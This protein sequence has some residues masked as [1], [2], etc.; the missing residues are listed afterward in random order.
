VAFHAG[1]DQA[2]EQRE[3]LTAE[4]KPFG[5]DGA[6]LLMAAC[7]AAVALA[8]W[9]TGRFAPQAAGSGI[10]HVKGVEQGQLSLW[11]LS[12]VWVKFVGGIVGI[13]GGLVLGREGP[14]VQMGASLADHLG[15]RFGLGVA[16]RRTLL[17]VGAGAGL[18]G[19]FNAPL[20][21]TLFA[22]EELGAPFRPVVYLGTLLAA[23]VTD[24]CVRFWLGQPAELSIPAALAPPLSTLGP[25]LLVGAA[26]G[27]FGAFFNG[28]LLRAL[29]LADRFRRRAPGWT[30]GAVLGAALG[31]VAWFVPD[32]PGGG[33]L[34]ARHVLDGSPPLREV[35]WLLP[36][37]FALTVASF[38]VGAPGGIFAP[39]LVLGA[40][41]GSA[42]HAGW[43]ALLPAWPASMPLLAAAGMAGLFAAVVRSPLTGAVLM[44]EM[45]GS[46]T[47]MLSV[48]AASLAAHAAAA[49]LGSEPIYD[50]LLARELRRGRG[51]S[52]APA[53]VQKR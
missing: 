19:A 17:V 53:E 28:T 6:L 34:F 50:S 20:A 43:L 31:A 33:V 2:L 45:T 15:L 49:A 12:V 42:L 9:L 22:V 29:A 10:Q 4:L 7:A 40:L 44:V 52:S 48:V 36:L 23:A 46:Y 21:G 25:A 13:G 24:L 27:A 30:L 38:A 8:V 3:R 41:L 11:P 32:L 26:A 1:L 5:V 51:M 14:T 18:A 35:L 16:S 47:L 37:C 39:L